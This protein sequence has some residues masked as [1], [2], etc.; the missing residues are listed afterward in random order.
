MD[1]ADYKKMYYALFNVITDAIQN[2][3]QQNY[4]EA[5]DLLICAQQEAEELFISVEEDILD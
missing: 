1:H 5:K 4:D 3:D 2:I